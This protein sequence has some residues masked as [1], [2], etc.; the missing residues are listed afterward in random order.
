MN[1]HKGPKK[2]PLKIEGYIGGKKIVEKLYAHEGID[3]Q[4]LLSADDSKLVA[5]GA[6]ST[7]IAMRVADE[8]GNLRRYSTA[9]ISLSLE[10]PADLIGENPFSLFGGCGA[11]W[12]RA[13]QEVGMVVLKARHPVLGT[14]EVR[15]ALEAAEPERV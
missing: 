4:L 12:V 7:R 15:I 2:G 8:Y 3:R 6:D 14:K 1:L 11:V 10:G 9:A 5:D 13:G